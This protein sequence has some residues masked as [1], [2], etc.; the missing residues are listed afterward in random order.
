MIA[1]IRL[2]FRHHLGLQEVVKMVGID[3]ILPVPPGLRWESINT[4]ASFSREARDGVLEQGWSA[5]YLLAEV[6]E[7]AD[8]LQR[9]YQ[10]GVHPAEVDRCYDDINVEDSKDDDGE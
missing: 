1:V 6:I 10:L 4:M 7:G 5:I 2:D 9:L 8:S 3:R